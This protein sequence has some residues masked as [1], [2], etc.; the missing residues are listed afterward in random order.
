MKELKQFAFGLI[1]E[2]PTIKEAALNLL[3]KCENSI[4]EGNSELTE[5]AKYRE[6]IKKL[7]E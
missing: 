5:V 1:Y 4:E 6:K 2:N 7:I 3:L